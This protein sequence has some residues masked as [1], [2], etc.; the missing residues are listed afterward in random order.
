M[1]KLKLT[2]WYG[3]LAALLTFFVIMPPDSSGGRTKRYGET[4]CDHP[5]YHCINIQVRTV[6]K[7]IKTKK[8]FRTVK[9]RKTDTWDSLFPDDHEREI[10]KR[11]NRMNIR[12]RKGMVIAVPND[13]AGKDYMNFAP[14]PKRYWGKNEKEK[15]IGKNSAA[16]SIKAKNIAS[17]IDGAKP[18]GNLS[19]AGPGTLLTPPEGEK[20]LVWD[21]ELLA[22]GAYDENHELVNWGPGIGG[23]NYCADSG[24]RCRTVTGVREISAK[25]G[26]YAVSGKYPIN[27]D[28][29]TKSGGAP[30]PYYMQFARGYG[31]HASST[32]PGRH[33]SHGCIRLFYEDAKWLHNEFVSIGMDIIIKPYPDQPT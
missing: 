30:I 9:K 18:L 4:L 11:L 24:R 5:G 10:V 25:R 27:K 15:Y 1:L 28:D 2:C 19:E 32:L 31:L 6:E 12:L 21:P 20:F 7:Q 16:L 3:L 8:G 23:K 29:K 22:W 33:A 17:T 13:M 14:Y 26:R